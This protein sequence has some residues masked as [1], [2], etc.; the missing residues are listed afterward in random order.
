LEDK[1]PNSESW[2]EPP[3]LMKEADELK[4]A[5]GSVSASGYRHA[6]LAY[7]FKLIY[8]DDAHK[9]MR[10]RFEELSNSEHLMREDPIR[11]A[12]QL[13]DFADR[14]NL[15]PVLLASAMIWGWKEADQSETEIEGSAHWQLFPTD[16]QNLR[17]DL[18][19]E[20][21]ALAD[22]VDQIFRGAGLEPEQAVQLAIEKT[23]GLSRALRGFQKSLLGHSEKRR[24]LFYENSKNNVLAYYLLR[25]RRFKSTSEEMRDIL[26]LA[27]DGF[28]LSRSDELLM[29]QKRLHDWASAFETLLDTLMLDLGFRREKR[30]YVPIDE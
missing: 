10:P 16:I 22:D 12:V 6:S 1:N 24:Q 14:L 17:K 18:Q 13:T 30:T 21:R 2:P 9:N 8:E 28:D 4:E 26:A 23:K 7:L 29:A 25:V 27:G 11:L 19:E 3:R 5:L 15:H 20:F